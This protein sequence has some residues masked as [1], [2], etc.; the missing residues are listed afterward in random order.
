MAK[1]MI[2]GRPG[3]IQLLET[4]DLDQRGYARASRSA[5]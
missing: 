4:L 5:P 2:A 3:I 1:G